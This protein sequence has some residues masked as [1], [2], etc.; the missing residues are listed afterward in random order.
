MT[1]NDP[2]GANPIVE[3]RGAGVLGVALIPVSSQ[4]A[5]VLP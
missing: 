1:P 2:A 5:E 3:A 4:T